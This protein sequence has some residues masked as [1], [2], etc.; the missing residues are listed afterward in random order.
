[1]RLC[2]RVASITLFCVY[3][4]HAFPRSV[5]WLVF[6]VILTFFTGCSTRC[7]FCGLGFVA[8]LSS[9]GG[10]HFLFHS[11][12]C[13]DGELSSGYPTCFVSWSKPIKPHHV[14]TAARPVQ[15]VFGELVR[16]PFTSAADAGPLSSPL[17]CVSR[18]S[19][20]YS[21]NTC[22]APWSSDGILSLWARSF[23]FENL[24][25]SLDRTP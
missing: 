24:F 16:F 15:F 25:G 20:G 3:Q 7:F 8:S 2:H 14:L 21:L 6:S 22:D 9:C 13:C 11:I 4:A 18:S 17:S 1:M 5:K 12:S 10:H 19:L 23:L